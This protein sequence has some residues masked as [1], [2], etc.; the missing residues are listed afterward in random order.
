MRACWLA[1]PT[2]HLG[3]ACDGAA[4]FDFRRHHPSARGSAHAIIIAANMIL[5]NA[6]RRLA[7]VAPRSRAIA[8]SAAS[9]AATAAT[10]ALS[11]IKPIGADSQSP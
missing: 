8:S 11:F 7:I 10:T 9:F 1:L 4:S 5:R 2:E 6:Y 3:G